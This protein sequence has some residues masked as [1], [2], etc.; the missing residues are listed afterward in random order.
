MANKDLLNFFIRTV[1]I[2]SVLV[3]LFAAPYIYRR[4]TQ[5][6]AV[7]NTGSKIIRYGTK[8][9][10]WGK[11]Q[12]SEESDGTS[13]VASARQLKASFGNL[14]HEL[15]PGNRQ[16]HL[17]FHQL[18]VEFLVPQPPEVIRMAITN[19]KQLQMAD[20]AAL[21]AQQAIARNNEN[22]SEGR[23]LR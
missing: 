4:Y 14:P 11:E 20:I 7:K 21:E 23:G 9:F 2:P 5:V 17:D 6:E 3:L 18:P 19:I 8:N 10:S 13:G 22:A 16:F 1:L 12:K 15:F